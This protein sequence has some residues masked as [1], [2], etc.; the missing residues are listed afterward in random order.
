MQSS[1]LRFIEILRSHALPVSPAE[2]LD[3][4]AA[5][6]VVGYSDREMLRNTLAMTL[7]KS[8]REEHTFFYCFDQFFDQQAAD[9]SGAANEDGDSESEPASDSADAASPESSESAGSGVGQAGAGTAVDDAAELA[10]AANSSPALQELLEG[11]LLPALLENQRGSLS[12]AMRR[13]GQDAGLSKIRLFTQK[14]QYTRRILDSLGEDLIRDAVIELERAESPA[15]DTLRRYRDVLREQVR[16]FV[17]QQ[18]LM[19]AEGHNSAFMEEILSKTRLSNIDRRHRERVQEQVQRMARRLASRH[20]ARR[21]PVKRGQLNMGK[22][23]RGGMAHDGILFKTHWRSRKRD[24]A[25]LLALCDVSG[26]V[27]AYASFLLMFLYS[28]QDVLPRTRSFAF[29]SHLGEISDLFKEEPVER[30]IELANWRYGGATDYGG[31][32]RDFAQLALDD[33][34]SS[35]SVIILGDARNNR[36]NPE[37]EIMQSIYQRSKQVIWLNPES[38]RAWGTGDSEMLRYQTA[39]HYCAPC[40]NLQQLER[41]VDQLLKSLR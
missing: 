32:F 28:L 16:D 34:N 7:A 13:A 10:A 29:S 41:V 19:N 21:R 31:S 8:D 17:E 25:Q 30:A 33:I 22:T 5:M 20:S 23:L 3:A 18:Y 24:K 4:A 15:I 35:T 14:G 26:S 12:T 1:L 36:G 6:E 27:A 9:F 39:C 40:S 2:T 11:D 38:R 37:L